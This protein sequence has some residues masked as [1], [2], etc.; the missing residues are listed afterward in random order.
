MRE[1]KREI[2]SF[3]AEVAESG[4]MHC[5]RKRVREGFPE[6]SVQTEFLRFDPGGVLHRVVILIPYPA[7]VGNSKVSR[8][9]C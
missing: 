3:E 9:P 5:R 7:G 2:K 6:N 4:F 1:F 8:K